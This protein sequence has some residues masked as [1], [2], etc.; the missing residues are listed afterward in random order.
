[1]IVGIDASRAFAS[2]R[3]GT[4]NYSYQ[5]IKHM[6]RL[7]GSRR[8]NFVL[9]T[10]P[11]AILPEWTEQKNVFIQPINY[12][13]LWTQVGLA[14]ATWRKFS[15]SQIDILWVPAHTL[16]ILRRPGLDTAVTIHG[17]EYQWLPEYR[18]WLQ[19]WYLPLSTF[20]AAKWAGSLIA[21]SKFT[22][23][24]LVKELHT[25]AKKIKVIYEGVEGEDKVLRIKDKVRQHILAK[26]MIHDTK[27]ILFVGTIQPRKNLT[28]LIQAF[29][30]ISDQ[31]PDYK[32]VVAGSV[33]WM[34]ESVLQTPG[35]LGVQEKV[36]FT[37]RVDDLVLTAL[38]QGAG[39]YVQ[40]SLTEGFG[41]PVLEAMRWGVPVVSSNGGAL[42]EVVGTAGVVVAL[43]DKF[44]QN[45][46]TAIGGVIGDTRW[47][48]E[49]I[50]RGYNRVKELTWQK[51]AQETLLTLTGE[52][53]SNK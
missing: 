27:Y 51:T 44:I 40:P 17:L 6:L 26:Y 45:L 25:D 21:V 3:T 22:R 48:K 33:G 42:G 53:D 18:N 14:W 39:I 30:R 23:D 11:N 10:R 35:R 41:L 52:E 47:Q 46:A 13:Y 31:I 12:R 5:V 50:T 9:F 38:Y 34:A 1:M 36:I 16:P 24:Q 4:E 19:R 20:Y 8:H 28:A 49:L 29:S 15:S 2:D 7:P 32:L 37:G 43:G